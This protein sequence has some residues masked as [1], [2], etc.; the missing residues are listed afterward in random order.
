ML[1]VPNYPIYCCCDAGTYV[2]IVLIIINS[3][4]LPDD[5]LNEAGGKRKIY[6]WADLDAKLRMDGVK[7]V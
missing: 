6:S 7:A 2:F 5:K 4:W 1:G 3:L